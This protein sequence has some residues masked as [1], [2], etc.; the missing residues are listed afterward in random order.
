MGTLASKW[1]RLHP[2]VGGQTGDWNLESAA[3]TG[4]REP[5]GFPPRT[6]GQLA[7]WVRQITEHLSFSVEALH[8]MG[9]CL[10]QPGVEPS[11]VFLEVA[12]E[13]LDQARDLLLAG[14]P[15]APLD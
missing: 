12:R 3:D 5:A 15:A 13:K 8:S 2:I 11:R 1:N 9:R 7:D 14:P 6:D 4:L 10:Q